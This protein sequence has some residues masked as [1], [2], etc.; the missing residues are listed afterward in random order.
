LAVAPS[1]KSQPVVTG[2]QTSNGLTEKEIGLFAAPGTES[3]SSRGG[4]GSKPA[5]FRRVAAEAKRE[6][7]AN[8][9]PCES[10]PAERFEKKMPPP[11]PNSASGAPKLPPGGRRAAQA[12]WAVGMV[13]TWYQIAVALPS[14]SRPTTP[15]WAV[16]GSGASCAGAPKVADPGAR[17][18]H[19][20]SVAAPLVDQTASASPD[21]AIT[22]WIPLML[23]DES[24]SCV[25]VVS[26]APNA[27]RAPR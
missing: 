10:P 12:V 13:V 2:L 11:P 22:S 21:G 15:F 17:A 7:A 8:A 18:D 4:T 19:R 26:A 6:T 24:M 14:P 5:T 3:E 9:L 20:T 25:P 16:A 27:L 23:S 1:P